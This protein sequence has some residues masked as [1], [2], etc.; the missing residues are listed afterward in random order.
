MQKSWKSDLGPH[1]KMGTRYIKPGIVI[2]VSLS[3]NSA[4]EAQKGRL[5]HTGKEIAKMAEEFREGL[6]G[7]AADG[8]R[9]IGSEGRKAAEKDGCGGRGTASERRATLGI[10]RGRGPAAWLGGMSGGAANR[11]RGSGL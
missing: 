5:R 6:L 10:V 9:V 1:Q 7:R 3:R 11:V 2:L 8:E 4:E